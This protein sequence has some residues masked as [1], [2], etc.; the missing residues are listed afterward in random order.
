MSRAQLT[1]TEKRARRR[2]LITLK[3]EVMVGKYYPTI[4]CKLCDISENG[5]RL[6][7]D[8]PT[9]LPTHFR[10]RIVK[11]KEIKSARTIWR[12][13]RSVGVIFGTAAGSDQPLTDNP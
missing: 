11:S 4:D 13:D 1:S 2:R 3:G 10:L 6:Q 9:I 5:A 8:H 12:A 7:F